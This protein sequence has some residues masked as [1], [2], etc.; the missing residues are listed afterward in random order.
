[1]SLIPLRDAPFFYSTMR[2]LI[3]AALAAIAAALILHPKV[4]GV[5]GIL[6]KLGLYGAGT[7]GLVILGAILL[8]QPYR[9]IQE[10]IMSEAVKLYERVE[11]RYRSMSHR[12]RADLATERAEEANEKIKEIEEET[13]FSGNG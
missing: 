11:R 8:V 13:E 4:T 10:I 7:F 3:L 2:W 9:Y 6:G 5:T 12:L 1:M